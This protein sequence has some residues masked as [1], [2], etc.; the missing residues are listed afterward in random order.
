MLKRL[1]TTAMVTGMLTTPGGG[2]TAQDLLD[3][4]LRDAPFSVNSPVIDLL[5]SPAAK[6]VVEAQYPGVLEKLPPQM[7]RTQAPSF[8]AIMSVQSMLQMMRLP[9]EGIEQLNTRLAQVPVTDTD[10]RARCARYDNESPQFDLAGKGPRV[11]VFHKINGFDHGPSVTAATDAIGKLAGALGWQVAVTDRGGAFTPETLAR[12]DVVVWNNV[13]GDVL[14]LSQRRAFEDYL[15][16]GGG[17]LGIHGSG[18]D[19][20]YFWDWYADTLLGAR[21]IGHPADPQFQEASIAVE[22]NPGGIGRALAPG[23][24]MSDEWYS[25]QDSPR[26]SGATVV[27]TLDEST[28]LP[29][30]YGGQDLRMGED[31][32][33]A[34]ARCVGE[35]RAFYTAIGHRP[36]VYQ[37]PQNTALLQDALVWAAGKGASGCPVPTGAGE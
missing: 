33:I 26:D 30:G 27:A 2:A 20:A 24:R 6:A 31:H 4:P 13:S 23:W 3:C 17:F 1:L 16:G 8:A 15:N 12:F 11:L 5:L 29:V 19:P 9:P 34:W 14:T 21:F 32:P 37:V 10:R 28:Y 25:F 18:G 36:E 35:G 7:S 22:A